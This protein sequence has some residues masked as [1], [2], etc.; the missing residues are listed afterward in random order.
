MPQDS[1][2]GGAQGFFRLS[3]G[4]RWR[5]ALGVG[6][7]CAAALASFGLLFLSGWLLAG[8]AVAGLGGQAVARAFNI[9]LPATGVRFFAMVRIIARYLERVVAH[10]GALRLGGHLRAWVYARLAPL[11]PAGL[12][13]Q[14]GGDLLGRFVSDTDKV[15]AYYTDVAL[16]FLRALLCG[17]VFVGVFACFT[18]PAAALLAAGLLLG[19]VLVPLLVGPAMD[20][21]VRREAEK[22]SHIQ[23]ELA[24]TLQNMGEYL[25][26]D[27][28]SG[29]AGQWQAQQAEMDRA[30]WKLDVLESAARGLITLITFATA[31]GVLVLAVNA[32]RAGQLSIAEVPMLVL[33]GLAAF[34]VAA[35]LPLARQA[36]AQAKLATIQLDAACPPSVPRPVVQGADLPHAPYDLVV[37]DLS[38]AYPKTVSPV[39]QNANLIIR[40]GEHVGLV[41]P[42]GIGKSS[43]IN[44]LFG[45]YA[46][47]SGSI[48]FGGVDV[49]TLRAEDMAAF[50]SVAAQDFHLFAGTLRDNLLLAAPHATE[51]EL[52]DV[53]ETAQLTQFIQ[54]LPQGLQTW[55][56]N[57]GLRLSGGQ[58]RRVAVAQALLRGTPWLVLDEPTEGLDAALEQALMAAL[59]QR[60]EQTT[61][62]CMTHRQ[63]VLPF[64]H[65]VIRVEDACFRPGGGSDM[66]S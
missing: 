23:A 7:A 50:V 14:Q 22:Q 33:G 18:L 51:Q 46:P 44:L 56:G 25:L 55:V 3:V 39:L 6:F 45:F 9:V 30:C 13:D 4:L 65:R 48:S 19:G 34:D 42:S 36:A 66:K 41:G 1:L 15:A 20:R 29:R 37:R 63:A 61:I 24:Q 28:A 27:A 12:M 60:C 10:D 47:D 26:L 35:P 8:A 40:Q 58:A 2:A 16:P 52:A 31:L 5:L 64:M 59:V 49:G 57:D 54:S 43:L 11:A 62:V 53:L 38:F 21:L 32:C 17:V